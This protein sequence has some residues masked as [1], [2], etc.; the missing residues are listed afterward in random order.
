[1]VVWP[2]EYYF[3]ISLTLYTN[4]NLLVT[5]LQVTKA[6][7]YQ[8]TYIF[9]IKIPPT[10]IKHAPRYVFLYSYSEA[11]HFSENTMHEYLV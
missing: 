10:A 11:K 5:S 7:I 1:M 9:L 6:P 2:I 3:Q 8:F 4:D